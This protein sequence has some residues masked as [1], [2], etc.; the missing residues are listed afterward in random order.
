METFIVNVGTFPPEFQK[1]DLLFVSKS[2]SVKNGDF[3]L[4]RRDD[5]IFIEKMA[6]GLKIMGRIMRHDRPV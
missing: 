2:S 5:E 6:H 4:V 3:V 1:G